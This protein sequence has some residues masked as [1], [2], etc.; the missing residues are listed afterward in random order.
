MVGGTAMLECNDVVFHICEQGIDK[1]KLGRWSFI[2]LNGKNQVKTTFVTVYCPVISNSPGSCYSQQL[3]YMAEHMDDVPPGLKCPR[4][5]FGCDLQVFLRE[6]SD[7]GH[8][9]VVCGDFNSEYE[10]LSEW[11]LHQG[12]VDTLATKHGKCPITY[13]IFACDPLDCIF[14]DPIIQMR[15]GGYLP[16][17]RLISDHR[18][19]FNLWI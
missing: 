16:F 1:R 2:T 17:S 5:L 18:V 7:L 12:L 4:Q 10:K 8:H 6:K 14:S 15:E 3:L 11:M 19:V 9:L 13:Q